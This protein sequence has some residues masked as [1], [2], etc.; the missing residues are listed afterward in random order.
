ILQ[1]S[2]NQ[3]VDSR[4]TNVVLNV[5]ENSS[6]IPLSDGTLGVHFPPLDPFVSPGLYI[7]ATNVKGVGQT[8]APDLEKDYLALPDDVLQQNL[9]RS[10][11]YYTT[12]FRGVPVRVLSAPLIDRSTG[13]VLGTIQ[14]VQPLSATLKTM[15]MLRLLFLVG[16]GLGLLIAAIGAYILSGRSLRPLTGITNTARR[17]GNSRDLSE[18]LELPRSN[19]E[20]QDLVETFNTML[21][22]LDD[23]FTAE[24]R[25]VSDA[26]HELRTPLTALRGNAEILLRQIEM[27][28][29][30]NTDAVEILTDIRDESER[31]GRLVQNLLTLARADVGWRPE[32]GPVQLDQIAFDS[33]RLATRISGT[34][35]LEVE[36]DGE[37]D[38]IGNSDQLKQLLLILLDNA[39]TYTPE[40]SSVSLV[41]ARQH[42]R[43]EILVHDSGPGIPQDQ[44]ERIFDRFFRGEAARDKRA[45]GAGLGLAIARWIVECHNG[46]IGATSVMG[47]GTTVIVS[48]P[49]VTNPNKTDGGTTLEPVAQPAAIGAGS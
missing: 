31:M 26:S 17:I 24:R 48:L 4:L 3:E 37:V 39:F 21:D 29:V 42:D 38:V 8:Q 36:V 43:A 33:A 13:R 32:L 49:R 40:G 20:V 44:L 16:L 18:R 5:T 22:R 25:F 35:Q 15:R 47:V 46:T 30:A 1:R 6:V 7:Q 41:V 23:A 12:E 45:V 28:S 10:P 9:T 34:H 27:G 19:D 2:L 11:T 14:A